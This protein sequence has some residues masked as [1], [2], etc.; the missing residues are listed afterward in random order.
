MCHAIEVERVVERYSEVP[1]SCMRWSVESEDSDL[2]GSLPESALRLQDR[3]AIVTGAASGIG[4][5]TAFALAN[6]G[7]A[8]IV[9]D[10]NGDGAD[11]VADGIRD[12]GGAARGVSVDVADESSI[13][14]MVAA[15]IT[16][17]GGLDILHNNAAASNAA[18]VGRDLAIEDLE[19][20]VWDAT[21]AVNL[22]GPMLGCKHAIPALLARGGG[23]IINTSSASGRTGDATRAAYGASKAGLES[24][25]RYVATQYGK[26]GVRCNAIA[27]GVIETPALIANVPESQISRYR[28]ATLT[29]RLGR[30]EDIAAAVV[31]LAS[32]EGAFIT[33]QTLCVDGGLLAHHPVL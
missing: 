9:A 14:A 21:M 19:V 20:E 24:L 17:F 1:E 28:A 15:A 33:G 2:T 22:R 31:F 27:P 7:A 23:T 26:R 16:H 5:A 29:P 12:R 11:Q 13:M 4:R 32:D 10:L 18:V 8:V 3:V 30:P 6:A 25:T